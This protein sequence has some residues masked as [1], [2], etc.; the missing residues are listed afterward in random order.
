MSL[1][2][3]INEAILKD[4]K[5]KKYD[6]AVLANILTMSKEESHRRSQ[7]IIFG[8]RINRNKYPQFIYDFQ[9]A[10]E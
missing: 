7:E 1:N 6:N 10:K 3:K 8:E 5:P 2:D 9:E 4:F